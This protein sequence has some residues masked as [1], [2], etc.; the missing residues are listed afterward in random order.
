MKLITQANKMLAPSFILARFYI[1]KGQNKKL[2]FG[3]KYAWNL[4]KILITFLIKEGLMRVGSISTSSSLNVMLDITSLASV[5]LGAM[6]P[7]RI[8][9]I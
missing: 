1:K 8:Q 9:T 4:F 3:V 5:Q 7:F 2:T 6:H